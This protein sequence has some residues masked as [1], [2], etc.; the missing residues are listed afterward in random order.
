MKLNVCNS[1]SKTGLCLMVATGFCMLLLAS[2]CEITLNRCYS[3]LKLVT[4]EVEVEGKGKCAIPS[5][6]PGCRGY[7]S[8]S[9]IAVHTGN[10]NGEASSK[11]VYAPE[12][13]CCQP[14]GN[15][16]TTSLWM[17]YSCTKDGIRIDTY[18]MKVAVQLHECSCKYCAPVLRKPQ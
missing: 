5:F 15:G 12:C 11:I 9:S 18:I 8:S 6:I 16:T 1:E 4:K 10:V 13:K 17:P 3:Y 14:T 7:C 2:S